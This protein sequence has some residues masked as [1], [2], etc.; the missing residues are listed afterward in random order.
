MKPESLWRV[1]LDNALNEAKEPKKFH[2]RF[3]PIDDDFKNLSLRDIL[4]LT[5]D[6]LFGDDDHLVPTEPI[7]VSVPMQT[8]SG[9]DPDPISCPEPQKNAFSFQ[10]EKTSE[11]KRS[12]PTALPSVAVVSDAGDAETGERYRP[13][14]SGQWAERFDELFLYR[15]STGNCL[16]PHTYTPNLALAR[17]VKRQRYQ[18]KRWTEGD[19]TTMTPE[20]VKA[21]EAIG[22]VWD[23]QKDSW[24]ARLDE[25]R[26]FRL[27]FMHSNVPSNYTGNQKL[28]T[29]V[30]CQ[31]R[32]RKLFMEGKPSNMSVDRMRKLERLEFE[33]ELRGTKK[34][35]TC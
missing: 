23:S 4:N 34:R 11:E 2:P 13:Y 5:D 7:P 29:W 33:W 24:E 35:R 14:Q 31:R 20:R 17:W 26:E 3:F 8:T 25:L 19:A 15:K 1:V 6:I 12:Q 21:L 10:A 9:V 27:K 22:F 32:Q 28:A 16:V 18:Y 30:K